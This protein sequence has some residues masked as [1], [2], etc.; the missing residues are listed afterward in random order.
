MKLGS[1]GEAF[2]VHQT[3]EELLL[4]NED[5]RASPNISPVLSPRVLSPRKKEEN[6][7]LK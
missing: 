4:E 3:T 6:E 5:I 2:F 7:E 1:A